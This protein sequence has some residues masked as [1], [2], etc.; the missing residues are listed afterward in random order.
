MLTIIITVLIANFLY[1]K[2]DGRFAPNIISAITIV[3]VMA[4]LGYRG[5]PLQAYLLASLV[6]W[7]GLQV[8]LPLVEGRLVWLDCTGAIPELRIGRVIVS[9]AP[10]GVV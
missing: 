7:F 8:V 1:R 6:M 2:S 3:T 10:I 4:M 5:L 9:V